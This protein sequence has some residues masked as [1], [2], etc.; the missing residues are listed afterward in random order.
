M[1]T[2]LDLLLTELNISYRQLDYWC[3]QGWVHSRYAWKNGEASD[4]GSGS[5]RDFT[6]DEERV[7]RRM[8]ALVNH[9]FRPEAAAR[10]AR[11]D[12]GHV[13]VGA[14]IHMLHCGSEHE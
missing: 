4:G 3:R 13:Y 8:A 10:I 9:G 12:G 14:G 2:Q 7:L 1:S 6:D 11:S 5:R